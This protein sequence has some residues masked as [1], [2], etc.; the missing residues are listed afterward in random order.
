MAVL[1]ALDSAQGQVAI[2][3]RGEVLLGMGA[4]SLYN[5]N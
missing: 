3:D 1:K 5:F 4:G 2:S